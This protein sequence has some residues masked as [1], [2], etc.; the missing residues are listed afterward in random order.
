MGQDRV[1]WLKVSDEDRKR[2]EQW[3]KEKK[4]INDRNQQVRDAKEYKQ[5]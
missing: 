5:R 3:Q 4:G 1:I 2:K